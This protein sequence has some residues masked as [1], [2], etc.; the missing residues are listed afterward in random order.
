MTRKMFLI[1]GSNHAFRVQFALPPMNASSG[2]PT[3][4]LY[5]FTTLFAKLIRE[6]QPDFV[7]VAFDKGKTFRHELFPEYKGHR[8]EMPEDLRQQWPHFPELVHAFGYPT[9]QAPGFEADDVLGTLARRFAGPDL[10]VYLVTGDKDYCQLV[11][12]NIVILDLMKEAEIGIAGVEEKFGVPPERVI[13]VLGLC[14]DAS[15]NIPGVPGVGP[16][17]AAQYIQKYGDLEG[18]LANAASVGG[19]TGEKLV[20]HAEDARLS[21]VL[22]T[23][24]DDVPLRE[25]LDDL[26]PKGVQ[27][28]A[29]RELFARWDFGKVAQKLLPESPKVE[30]ETWLAA[31]TLEEAL[32]AIR[33]ARAAGTVALEVERSGGGAPIGLALSW[34][35]A[36]TRYICLDGRFGLGF[37]LEHLRAD[38][39]AAFADPK[40][41]WLFHDAKAALHAL[42]KWSLA[43]VGGLGDT[44]LADYVLA[45]HE[46]HG[47]PQLA[48]RHLAYT[49]KGSESVASLFAEH[50]SLDEQAKG[51]G[52]RANL[53]FQLH[54]RILSRMPAGGARVYQELELPLVP[55]LQRMEAAGIRLD[56]Q[57]FGAIREDIAARVEA[58][59][60][61]CHETLGRPFNVGSTKDLQEILF[62]ELGLPAGKKTK[63]GYSTDASVLEKLA[64]LHPLPAAILEYR[65]LSKLLSTYLDT[66]PGFVREDG[67]IHTTFSQ[68]VAATGR[69]ASTDPNLQNIPIRTFE[70]RRIRDA[71]VP[72]EGH[73]FLSADYSQVE[74]RI[75]AHFCGEGPLAEAFRAGIDIHRR[76]ASEVFGTPLEEVTSAQRSAAKAINFGLLYGMSAFR[77]A[78][79]LAIPR[80]EAERYMEEYFGRMPQVRDWIEATKQGAREQ[81]W[82]ETLF[83]RR[84]LIGEIHSPRFNDRAAAEREA[85]N[86]P[87]QGTA[88]DL[89]KVAMIRV[90]Q[91]LAARGLASRVILQVHDELLLEVPEAELEAARALVVEA[92]Q[93]AADLLVPLAVNTAS[94]HTWNQAHG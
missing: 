3:R 41:T 94:G 91:A 75:L 88:A 32:E 17:K 42:A 92:M 12:E 28:E 54:E 67:R 70:G 51:Q 69:L 36:D 76:T 56:L 66:L 14:G 10:K 23:I 6:H 81:G 64:D 65:M 2:F 34:G 40:V 71:F 90:D 62:T 77:L 11:N 45:S 13:D 31:S 24:R 35:R 33:A 44:L 16:K 86:T 8:P 57:V 50:L 93:G 7:A 72:A 61:A 79:D 74:L 22:A 85:V 27:E 19:K 20:E 25:S 38:L 80:R 15:D 60:R 47:L 73:V 53:I 46:R 63:T 9:V 4:A 89:M 52:E 59:E 30:P 78:G 68:A 21:R 18:V 29:L 84:R 5:G 37:G 55:V 49:L 43:P 82:V 39:A 83:G 58:A 48:E 26:A 1:D 87:V